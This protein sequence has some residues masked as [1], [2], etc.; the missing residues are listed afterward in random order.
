MIKH[1]FLQH[2]QCNV[3]EVRESRVSKKSGNNEA[4]VKR[5]RIETPSPLPTFK[6]KDISMQSIFRLN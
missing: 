3:E 4:T 5:A 2:F 6:V 1:R